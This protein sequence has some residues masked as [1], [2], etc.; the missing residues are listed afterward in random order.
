MRSIDYVDYLREDA[1]QELSC[2]LFEGDINRGL[3]NELFIRIIDALRVEDP[4]LVS[5]ILDKIIYE[6][7]E[8]KPTVLFELTN[9]INLLIIQFGIDNLSAHDC[10]SFLKDL[11]PVLTHIN[12][13]F[14]QVLMFEHLNIS[15]E[16][17]GGKSHEHFDKS[18]SDFIS[19]AAHELKTPLTLLEGYSEMLRGLIV[20]KKV[21]DDH[22]SLLLDGLD[23]GSR[24][25]REIINDMIDVSLIENDLLDL[26]LQPTWI[27]KLL[28]RIKDELE[29]ALILRDL[30][31]TITRFPGDDL[32]N[33]YDGDRLYQA[34]FNVIANGIKFTPDG[35][36]IGVNGRIIQ[37]F[38][39]LVVVDSGIG[40]D[41]MDQAKIFEIFQQVGDSAL[42]SSGKIKF[43]GGGPGLGLPIAKGI[44]EAHGGRI[45]V[46]SDGHDEHLCPGSSFH[47]LLPIK[48]KAPESN[49]SLMF[50]SKS[51]HK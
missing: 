36:K 19:I 17:L 29:E 13:Y 43:K 25:L 22:I 26:N 6:I 42:H 5:P 9:R 11:Q 32:R 34:I 41:P 38:I 2:G 50:E 14:C 1:I 23:S 20:Q 46:E 4:S 44:I 27:C 15:V 51:L 18:K 28:D 31:L 45:W 48:E 21:F 37:E 49:P 3:L 39:E 24:R 8:P 10:K 30:S 40:I 12:G 16:D 7:N 47:I 33:F 35:G